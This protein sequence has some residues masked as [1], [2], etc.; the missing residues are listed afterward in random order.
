MGD[1]CSF[2]S[3]VGGVCGPDSRDRK[4]NFELIPLLSC[5]KD[6]SDHIAR[7]STSIVNEVDLI[8]CRAAIFRRPENID[9]MTICPSHRG[10]L[11]L[12]WTR[13]ASTRCRVPE[14]LSKH[15]TSGKTGR[16]G[17]RAIDKEESAL[18]LRKTGVFLPVGSGML[19]FG[20]D[21]YRD[22]K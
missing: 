9:S 22:T 6:I 20:F 14:L 12:G 13:G 19:S 17:E 7:Y 8:L 1:S 5:K 21:F 3:L 16:K 15:G 4:C 2:K 18:I 10:K 11:G